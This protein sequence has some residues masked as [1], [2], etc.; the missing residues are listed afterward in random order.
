M[1]NETQVR[2]LKQLMIAVSGDGPAARVL[3]IVLEE[4]QPE[5]SPEA[6][7]SDP[8][9]E[10]K[11]IA[12]LTEALLATRERAERAEIKLLEEIRK[13]AGGA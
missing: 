11:Q 8:T 3:S 9:P 7:S 10:Q 5:P 12:E 4:K 2:L 6:A 13:H 1:L